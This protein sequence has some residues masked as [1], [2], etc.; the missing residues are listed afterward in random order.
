MMYTSTPKRR[1]YVVKGDLLQMD[2]SAIYQQTHKPEVPEPPL[3]K[4][5]MHVTVA[6]LVLTIVIAYVLWFADCIEY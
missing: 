3:H 4:Y 1:V 2:I 6:T 5:L